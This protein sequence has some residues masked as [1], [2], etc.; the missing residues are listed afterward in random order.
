MLYDF[1][2]RQDKNR[3]PRVADRY[4]DEKLIPLIPAWLR[5]DDIF[6]LLT[7]ARLRLSNIEVLRLASP[8]LSP[9]KTYSRLLAFKKSGHIISWANPSYRP[10]GA[11]NHHDVYALSKLGARLLSLETAQLAEDFLTYHED[12]PPSAPF[13]SHIVEVGRVLVLFERWAQAIGAKVERWTSEGQLHKLM[14]GR[15]VNIP[16]GHLLIRFANGVVGHVFVEMDRGTERAARWWANKFDGY[17]RLL[18]SGRFGQLFNALDSAFTII[19]ITPDV[20]RSTKLVNQC[21][22]RAKPHIRP[23]FYFVALDQLASR[24]IFTESICIRGDGMSPITFI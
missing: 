23:L 20:K 22:A 1:R 14:Q 3:K 8:G 24:N 19:T 10:K 6:L 5:D 17:A 2:R 12:R 4:D 21:I 7:I 11:K 15:G 18:D 9:R 16:D 13:I